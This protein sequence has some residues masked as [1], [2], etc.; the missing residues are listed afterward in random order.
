MTKHQKY[1]VNR[2]IDWQAHYGNWNHPHRFMITKIL[3][4][5]SWLSLMEIGCAAGANLMNIVKHI[6]GRQVG[7]ID[8]NPDA[9]EA[10][11]KNFIGNHE[12]FKVGSAD[13]IMMSDKSTDVT[14]SDMTLIYASPW[15]I[16]RYILEI[17]RITRK[18]VVICEFHSEKWWER[19]WAFLRTGYGVYDYEKLLK[20]HGFYDIVK[21]KIP[22]ELW[23]KD[24][25]QKFRYIIT[26]KI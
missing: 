9:I 4:G 24:L 6:P 3:M 2:K 15:G 1:W 16:G 17:K 25:N 22:V 20:K 10:A 11:K 13:N 12:L 7:G 19:W 23:G 14:L 21:Y 18:Y 26:A 8:I 5:L